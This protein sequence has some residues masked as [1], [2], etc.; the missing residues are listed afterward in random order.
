MLTPDFLIAGTVVDAPLDYAEYAPRAGARPASNVFTG[1]LRLDT[2]VQQN[3]F[4]LQHDSL[5]LV[6]PARPGVDTLPSFS[7]EFVQD[8]SHLVPVVRG[9]VINEHNWWEFVLGTGAVWD[10]DNDRGWSRA[11][12]P[13]ALMERRE[14]CLHNGVL[15]FLFRDGGEVSMVAFQVVSQTCNYLQFE[16]AGLLAAQY[17]PGAVANAA[18]VLSRARAHRSSRLPVRSIAALGADFPGASPEAF[19][20]VEEID[21]G[22]MTAYGVLI[23]GTHYVSGC[24]TRYGHYPYC[25]ELALPSYSTAKSIV[26]GFSLMLLEAA[27]PGAAA[28]PIG[29]VVPACSHGWHD[30]TIEHALDMTTGHFGSWELHGDEDAAVNGAFFL[31]DHAGRVDFACNH[32]PRQADPGT[33]LSYHTWD[34]YLAGAA[35]NAVLRLER[36]N[37]ADFFDDLLL[38]EVFEPLQLSVGAA[39]TRRTYDAERQPYTGYGLVLQRDDIAKIARFIGPMDGRI[40]N[41]EPLYRPMFDAI[42]QR[43]PT[44]P[45]LVA[46]LEN[47]RYNNGFRSF[48]VS[49]YLGCTNPAWVVVLSGF[50]GIIVAVMPNDTAYYYVSDGGAFRYLSAV[51]E[52]HRIRPMCD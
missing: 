37:D 51:R 16:M 27:L 15:T 25:D 20:S 30:V 5:E 47:I 13:F 21:P 34:T 22:D 36:G 1:R 48:D 50:G 11:A 43:V 26:G 33:H 12:I 17:E 19:G 4:S 32:F 9:P 8:G 46:E 18:V 40:G 29:S 7:F 39:N 24:N 2:G 31:S 23:D 38:A 49:S 3:Y 41:S 6:S 10:E 44:D 42:K 14:N 35:M 28:T 45:G 52:S